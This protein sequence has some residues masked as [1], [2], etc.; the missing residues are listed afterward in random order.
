VCARGCSSSIDWLVCNKIYAFPGKSLPS[1][2][3]PVS[4]RAARS[5]GKSQSSL[6]NLFDRRRPAGRSGRTSAFQLPGTA[7]SLLLETTFLIGTERNFLLSLLGSLMPST[8]IISADR[9]PLVG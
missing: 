5:G 6:V 8:L 9:K 3:P 4:I 7:G 2:C 1:I